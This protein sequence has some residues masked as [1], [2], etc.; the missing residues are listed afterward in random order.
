MH[1]DGSRNVVRKVSH[2][3]NRKVWVFKLCD[4]LVEVY[5]EDVLVDNR[6][7]VKITQGIRQNGNQAVINL[8]CHDFCRIFCQKLSQSPNPRTDFDDI[9]LL[10]N[11]S[12]IHNLLKDIGIGQEVLTEGFFKG[13]T[14]TLQHCLGHAII[15][16]SH[17]FS[18][19]ISLGVRVPL[20]FRLN[21]WPS[22]LRLGPNKFQTIPSV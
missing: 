15:C 21:N 22:P 12:R 14:V 7:I 20:Y 1:E 3:L 16:N 13:K 10:I 11:L 19:L 17:I 2:Y 18:F 4:V 9:D 8:K 6:D 5:L